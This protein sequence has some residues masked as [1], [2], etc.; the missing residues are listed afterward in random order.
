MQCVKCGAQTET[1]GVRLDAFRVSKDRS[2]SHNVVGRRE[3]RSEGREKINSINN[4]L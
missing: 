3:E 4:A 2:L 1:G